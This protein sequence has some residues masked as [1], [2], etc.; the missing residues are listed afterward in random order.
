MDIRV[1]DPDGLP[2]QDLRA[3]E[4]LVTDERRAAPIVL[5]Q[6]IEE[7][8]GTYDDV[9][10]RTSQ[11]EVSTNRG[12]PRGHL[13]L[14]VFDQ[15]HIAP[16]NEQ[17][18]RIAA[19]QFLKTRMR[20]GD[21]VAVF[22]LPGPGPQLKFTN[23]VERALAELPNVRG[24][25]E[26]TD[27]TGVGA[28]GVD[29]AYQIVRGDQMTLARVVSRLSDE[30]ASTDVLGGSPQARKQT[31]DNTSDAAVFVRAVKEN[32]GTVVAKADGDARRFLLLLTRLLRQMRGIEGRKAIILFSEGFFVDHVSREIEDAAAAAAQSYSVVYAL[33]L[34][35]RGPAASDAG[36]RGGD[37]QREEQ[38]RI[39]PLG[40]L[41]VETDGRLFLDANAQLDRALASIADQSQDYYIVGFA[42]RV[43]VSSGR[44]T[45]RRVSV[46]VTRPGARVSAR[47]GYA[48]D[49][50]DPSPAARRRAID[51]AFAA[52]FPEQSL[53][54]E[55][56]T[57][58]LR[59]SAAG[60]E[61]VV[62][63]IAADIPVRADRRHADT[64]AVFVV[65]DARTG[66]VAA[67]GTHV[68]S[69]QPPSDGALTVAG[70][71][72]IQVEIPPG[73][74]VARAV[75]REPGGLVGSADRRFDVR[76]ADG[77]GINASDL[78]VGSYR[79]A[80]PVRVR[81]S[82]ADVLTGTLEIYGR[83]VDELRDVAVRVEFVPIGGDSPVT[84]I[85]ADLL[86]VTPSARGASRVA[87]IEMPLS[88]VTPGQYVVRA[89]V[90][91]AGRTAATRTREIEVVTAL[92]GASVAP[93]LES[94]EQR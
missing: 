48:I 57:Y 8:N 27:F 76:D 60:A 71:C 11:G 62:L 40:S 34:N 45:Y 20:P 23:D 63:A 59:G 22:T 43:D 28:M 56:T 29:E 94:R 31:V 39:E 78:I 61:K 50:P 12:A 53:P 81:T 13:Y 38:S 10:R 17:R 5:F 47:T 42:P 6:H 2:I 73:A 79:D 19:S 67:S 49:A 52:P 51:T 24:G 36:P 80:L 86:D 30:S 72:R 16:G 46:R 32:A 74:Y 91:S 44:S 64:D 75:V 88:N 41:A 92:A 87:L 3:D 77:P 15:Q 82:A 37:R 69:L 4:V 84:A 7:P 21:R 58:G 65:Q 89:S 1:T 85:H 93:R 9:S 55:F 66:R 83:T 25:L 68:L 33:D 18:A 26:R 35:R 90:Q 54:V 70:I 14:L